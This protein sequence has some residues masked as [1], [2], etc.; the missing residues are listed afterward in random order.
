MFK[1]D[2]KGFLLV[3]FKEHP[4]VDF[5]K[6]QGTLFDV[7]AD[8]FADF[9]SDFMDGDLFN[10]EQYCICL[11]DTVFALSRIE[12]SNFLNYQCKKMRIPWLWLSQFE[13]L[14]LRNREYGLIDYP[15]KDMDL[16]ARILKEKR[17]LLSG[18]VR[19]DENKSITE[20]LAPLPKTTKFNIIKVIEEMES[21]EGFAA[22]RLF[23]ERRKKEYFQEQEHNPEANFIKSVDLELDF[24]DD[25]RTLDENQEFKPF[26]FTGP[27]IQLAYYFARLIEER[28]EKDKLIFDGSK[29][30]LAKI[31][32][33]AFRRE[34]GSSFSE[35]SIRKYLTDYFNGG[36]KWVD[37][38][39]KYIDV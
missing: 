2:S 21:V 32:C 20:L 18:L 38:N 30:D 36:K 6:T 25:N 26:T 31:I 16:L 4:V 19:N 27:P 23:L 5:L 37:D 35:N 17:D 3:E 33:L 12:Q 28:S 1:N 11:L 13:A 34:D 39:F 7:S 14:L 10:Y 29:S 9:P 24:M 22:K 8:G 15:Q